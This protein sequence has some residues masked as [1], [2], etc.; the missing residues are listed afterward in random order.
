MSHEVAVDLGCVVEAAKERTWRIFL[1]ETSGLQQLHVRAKLRF[2]DRQRD[3]LG[4]PSG[5]GLFA[6]LNSVYINEV[7]KMT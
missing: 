2:A 4:R 5:P 3:T 7:T 6:L 1:V